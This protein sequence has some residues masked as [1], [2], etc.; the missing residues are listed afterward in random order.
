VP[1]GG[2]ADDSPAK[3]GGLLAGDRIV[4]LD[5]VEISDIRA[6]TK[7][8]R[9]HKPGDKVALAV[10]RGEEEVVLTIVLGGRP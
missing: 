10:K 4:K 8:L 3:L 1:V 2:V 6:L 9:E 7:V 5:Q